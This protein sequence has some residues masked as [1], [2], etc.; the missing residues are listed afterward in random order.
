MLLP[1]TE[2]RHCCG[3]Q[4]LY[5][6]HVA[7]HYLA[8]LKQPVKD[9]VVSDGDSSCCNPSEGSDCGFKICDINYSTDNCYMLKALRSRASQLC[10]DN[11]KLLVS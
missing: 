3:E 1:L 4:T 6:F 8:S 11:L 10:T 7:L 2:W 9:L 5:L